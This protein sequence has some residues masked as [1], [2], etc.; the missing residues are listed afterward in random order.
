[1]KAKLVGSEKKAANHIFKRIRFYK[2]LFQIFTSNFL[3]PSGKGVLQQLLSAIKVVRRR[4]AAKTT[5]AWA[6]ILQLKGNC[7]QQMQN[8]L[9]T[10]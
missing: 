4:R 10:A 5:T 3:F 2:K 9:Q 1:V 8:F 6:F 7:G